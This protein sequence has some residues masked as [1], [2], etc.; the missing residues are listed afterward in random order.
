MLGFRAFLRT[1]F[2]WME[3]KINA[4]KTP[5]VPFK[6]SILAC[7]NGNYIVHANQIVCSVY[8]M[9]LFKLMQAVSSQPPSC[10]D[11]FMIVSLTTLPNPNSVYFKAYMF[12]HCEAKYEIN[13]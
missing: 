2:F 4:N 6:L 5:I 3:R 10:T 12:L 9:M 1:W 11:V 13:K 8:Y 7:V